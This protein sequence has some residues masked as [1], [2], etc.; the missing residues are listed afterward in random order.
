MKRDR[1]KQLIGIWVECYNA[2]NGT[3]F[4]V[5]SYPDEQQR[6]AKS[7]DALCTSSDGRT[8]MA[9]EHTRI[10]AFP[11]E[12]TDTARFMD[13]MS[14]YEKDPILAEP[15]F[16]TSASLP[17]GS[18]PTGVNWDRLGDD[19]G[20]FLKRNHPFEEKVYRFTQ[21]KVEIPIRITKLPL[22]SAHGSFLIERDWPGKSNDPTIKKRLEEKLPK[23]RG[24]N[25][26]LKTLLLEQEIPAGSVSA[27]LAKYLQ[28]AGWSDWL[29]SEIWLLRTA[30]FST[31]RYVHVSQ[32][33]PTANFKKANWKD[34]KITL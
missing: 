12:K 10:E 28:T 22:S 21:D 29:P 26:D 4:R 2:L 18:V 5:T 19:I 32:Q 11:G 13:V 16:Q 15:G 30:G 34:G 1:D 14:R 8:T 7:I 25:T 9:V 33:H 23:L 24:A 31:E 6:E 3:A 27:D 20:A 17:V